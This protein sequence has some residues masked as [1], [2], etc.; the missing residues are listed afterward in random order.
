VARKALSKKLRFDV[1]KRD[2]FEC[3]Y[4]GATPPGVLLH[5]DHVVPVAAGGGN[6]IDNL[7][8]ACQPCNLGKSAT[9]LSVVPKSLKEKAADAQELEDQVQGYQSVLAAMRERVEEQAWQ[10]AYVF[11]DVFSPGCATFGRDWFM[12]IKRFV[13][14]LGLHETLV[15]M[16]IATTKKGHSKTQCFK[17]FCGICWSKIK[18]AEE[19]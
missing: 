4:C 11:N 3:V 8:T 5:V 18:Q 19:C 14:R 9:P 6:E 1:F 17:Y 2:G 12:S 7:V 13:E 10:V 15:A 16:E